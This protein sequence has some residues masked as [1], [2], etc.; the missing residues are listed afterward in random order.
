MHPGTKSGL[1]SFIAMVRWSHTES[2]F[3]KCWKGKESFCLAFIH[4]PGA[5][6]VHVSDH[7]DVCVVSK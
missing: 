1:G 7:D 5:G 3:L 2:V 4:Q 6:C